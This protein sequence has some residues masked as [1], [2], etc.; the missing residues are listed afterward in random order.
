MGKPAITSSKL[1]YRLQQCYGPPAPLPSNDPL[2]LVIWE[3]LARRKQ[4]V[5]FFVEGTVTVEEMS[6]IS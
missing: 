4:F 2:E 3:N 1:I 5:A 6:I